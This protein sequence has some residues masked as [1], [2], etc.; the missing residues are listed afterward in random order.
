MDIQTK[1]LHFIQEFLRL[2]DESI[3]DKLNKLLRSERKKKIEREL[4]PFTK[5][6]LNDMID[7]AEEDSKNERLTSAN[8]L[9]KEVDSWN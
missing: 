1:K 6:E 8:D 9:K 3:I 5:K 2:Q 7:S 4:K